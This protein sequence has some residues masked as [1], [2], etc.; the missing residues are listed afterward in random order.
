MASDHHK[1]HQML[2]NLQHNKYVFRLSQSE[3]KYFMTLKLVLECAS[4]AN[5]FSTVN[6]HLETGVEKKAATKLRAEHIYAF[7]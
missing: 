1:W 2:L 6:L 5:L 4:A 7:S 3:G